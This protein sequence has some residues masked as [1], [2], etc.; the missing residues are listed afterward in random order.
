MS[1][2]EKEYFAKRTEQVK[3]KRRIMTVVG[4]AGFFGSIVFGGIKTIL[5]EMEK[6]REQPVTQ[7]PTSQ[8][9][10]QARGYE[11]VLQR[12]PNNTLALE[13]LVNLRLQL[14]DNQG[15]MELIKRLVEL[16]P[17]RES[18]RSGLATLQQR[19]GNQGTQGKEGDLTP[20]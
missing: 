17:E 14:G 9:E 13:K 1:I 7:S 6:Q 16:H 12:E 15:A 8:L 4:V 18:Y 11:L 5:S 3:L 2:S 10:N 19:M 20:P